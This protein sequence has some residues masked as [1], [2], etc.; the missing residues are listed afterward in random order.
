MGYIQESDVAGL[1]QD[2]AFVKELTG[3][4]AQDPAG[5]EDLAK[6]VADKLSDALEDDATVRQSI[7]QAAVN[8]PE[9][10]RKVIQK[11]IQEMG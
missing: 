10:K 9:F 3:A 5:L 2:G 11:I 6:E 7:L 4:V 8:N 1:L